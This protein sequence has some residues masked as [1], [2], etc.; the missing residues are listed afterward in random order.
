VTLD[1]DLV[2]GGKFA[3]SAG[4]FGVKANLTREDT[5]RVTHHFCFPEQRLIND[6]IREAFARFKLPLLPQSIGRLDKTRC[7]ISNS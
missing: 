5:F 3:Y 4:N 1:V 7:W 6:A 2:V